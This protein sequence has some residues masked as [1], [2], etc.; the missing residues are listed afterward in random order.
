MV[1]RRLIWLT[2]I[3]V[4]LAL[5]FPINRI[6]HGGTQLSLPLDRLIPLFPAAVVPYILAD[7]L[8]IGLPVW[9]AFRTKPGEFE[10]YAFS[11]LTAT[12]ISYAV[13]ILFPTFA[14]RPEITSND[15]FSQA[16]RLLFQA[17]KAY[18]AAPSGHAVFTTLAYLYLAKW[19]PYRRLLWLAAAI[20]MLASAVLIKQHNILDLISGIALAVSTYF[21]WQFAAKR[22]VLRA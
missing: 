21:A 11:F 3:L 12:G 7:T 5:Y 6:A 18:N 4:S 8:I 17:D 1:R 9:A 10:S 22:R 13:Y 20:V 15:I 2:V 14:A 16:L 19:K